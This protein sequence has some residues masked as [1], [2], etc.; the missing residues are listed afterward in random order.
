M[1]SGFLVCLFVFCTVRVRVWGS[2]HTPLLRLLQDE[3]F[4]AQVGL[5]LE[6][7]ISFVCDGT[8]GAKTLLWTRAPSLPVGAGPCGAAR[9]RAGPGSTNGAVESR[10]AGIP[11]PVT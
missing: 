4:R 3:L 10:L 11:Q 1:C 6:Q 9:G 7:L 2:R 8:S 5:I